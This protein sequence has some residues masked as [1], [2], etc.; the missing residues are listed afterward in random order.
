[1]SLHIIMPDYDFVGE[2]WYNDL[3][4]NGGAEEFKFILICLNAVGGRP[5]IQK[6]CVTSCLQFNPFSAGTIF[7]RQNLTSV[8]VIF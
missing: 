7:I 2:W 4:Y 3:M 1:M 8:D 6:R 5:T